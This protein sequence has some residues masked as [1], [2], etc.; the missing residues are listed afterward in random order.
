MVFIF[1]VPY[2]DEN[3][4]T[5][6]KELYIQYR[7]LMYSTARLYISNS[8]DCED[9]V[10]DSVE[11]LCKKIQKLRGL[12]KCALPMYISYTVKHTALNFQR[13]QAVINRHIAELD[14]ANY[15][16]YE[17][18]ELSLER[19]EELNERSTGLFQMW[20]KL[21]EQDRELLYRK[22]VLGQTN[23]E[24][25]E[26]FHCQKDSVRMRLTRARR[27]AISLM[28]GGVGNDQT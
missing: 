11:S 18:P 9:I 19:I 14:G 28:E 4:R 8:H 21:P 27:K 5:F 16:D 6:M 10:Q 25:A 24:L 23:E 2:E 1:T 26:I 22:Y 20:P 15:E 17:L 12:P 13:H 3:D 7:R